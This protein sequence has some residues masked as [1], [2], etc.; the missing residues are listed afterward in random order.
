MPHPFCELR[1]RTIVWLA[2]LVAIP[3]LPGTAT[4]QDTAAAPSLSPRLLVDASWHGRPIR[5]PLPTRSDVADR[6]PALRTGT[7]F[8]RPAAPSASA[9]CNTGSAAWGTAPGRATGS[10]AR[11]PRPQCS[12]SSASTGSSGQ[13]PS[14]R[15]RCASCAA[16]PRSVLRRRRFSRPP[17]TR[18]DPRPRGRPGQPGHP[19]LTGV[20]VRRLADPARAPRIGARAV[21]L[22]VVGW[23]ARRR[24]QPAKAPAP[25]PL[26][27]F[28]AS[29]APRMPARRTRPIA[30]DHV[31]TREE[32]SVAEQQAAPD[33]ISRV[34]RRPPLPHA[35]PPERRAAL[36]ERI[37]V[38]RSHGM[39]LQDIADQLTEDG[40]MTLGGGR[41]W[42]P[43]NVRSAMKP[44]NA[45]GRASSSQ[46]HG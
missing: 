32:L 45:N 31:S 12:R 20:Y 9:I 22:L 13:A 25:A 17:R 2:V 27:V 42:H 4:A 5:R 26:T 8:R 43:W 29:P 33:E 3:A 36:R 10:S 37:L 1:I 28:P 41:Q 39:T 19:G 34:P 15:R 7:G 11:G 35:A 18:C 23:R 38:M 30:L 14:A 24:L 6:A 16:A 40:E 44:I 21:L 46:R